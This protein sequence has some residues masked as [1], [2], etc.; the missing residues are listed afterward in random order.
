VEYRV[1]T[2]GLQRMLVAVFDIGDQVLAGLSMVAERERLS[3]AS[4]TAIGGVSSAPL[5]WYDLDAQAYVE[6][7]VSEQAEV[8]S[9]LGDVARDPEGKPTVHAHAVLGLRNGSTRG[10]HLL[11]ARVRPTLEVVLRETPSELAKNYRPELG[12]ALID[13]NTSDTASS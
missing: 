1:L 3:A 6:I 4:L 7:E 12:L 5:G 10:G 8:L 13:L 2:E 11:E 9:L